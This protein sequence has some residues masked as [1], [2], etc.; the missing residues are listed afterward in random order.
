MRNKVHTSFAWTLAGE[1]VPA[2]RGSQHLESKFLISDGRREITESFALA[3]QRSTRQM[4]MDRNSAATFDATLA[5]L[6]RAL[7]GT[8]ET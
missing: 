6:D 5:R 3:K 8:I 4:T 2:P 1:S 7:K